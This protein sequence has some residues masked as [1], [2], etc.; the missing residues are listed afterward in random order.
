MI[1]FAAVEVYSSNLAGIPCLA[2]T[3]DR[4][5]QGVG[6][7]LVRCCVAEAGRQNVLEVM[8]ISAG[9]E[10]LVSCGFDYPLPG[11]KWALF[12][13]ARRD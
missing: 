9:N 11:R 10:F 3:P 2:V 12:I 8:A 13:Q 4:Q 7:E 1:G 6:K 5:H